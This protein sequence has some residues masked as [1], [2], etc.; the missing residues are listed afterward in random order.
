M[1]VACGRA[2][3]VLSG[4]TWD[5][6]ATGGNNYLAF[7]PRSPMSSGSL[8]LK[9]MIDWLI[10]QGRVQSNATLGQ[11][12]FGVEVVSTGGSPATF[13]FTDFSLTS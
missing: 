6:Y 7:V 10:Q 13:Q 11:V 8:D 5:V 4:V 1:P 12:C 9:A 2:G 3:V